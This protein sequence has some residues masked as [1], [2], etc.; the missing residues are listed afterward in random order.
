[1]PIQSLFEAPTV[2]EMLAVIA[3]NPQNK[4]GQNNMA[5]EETG[6]CGADVHARCRELAERLREGDAAATACDMIENRE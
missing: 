1:M 6:K 3:R 5:R 4:I 2:E